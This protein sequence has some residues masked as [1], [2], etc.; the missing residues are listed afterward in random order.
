MS[1][2]STS[3]DTLPTSPPHPPGPQPEW[4]S[5]LDLIR[6]AR[7]AEVA[8]VAHDSQSQQKA[9]ARFFDADMRKAW[10]P[11][12][13]SSEFCVGDGPVAGYLL[14]DPIV[15]Y[16]D[17]EGVLVCLEDKCAHRSAPLSLG[18]VTPEGELECRYDGWRYTSEGAVCYIPA[19]LPDR[20]IPANAYARRYP[21]VEK[22][23]LIW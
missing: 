19:L 15:L 11:F 18:R 13:M 16:R 2:P 21:T 20:K 7:A 10:Y 14:D 3:A 5:H 6:A 8:E 23:G 4:F 17:A 12:A 1:Q 22:D 9:R